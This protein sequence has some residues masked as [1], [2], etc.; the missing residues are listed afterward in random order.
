MTGIESGGLGP[1]A[2]LFSALSADPVKLRVLL[3]REIRLH[4]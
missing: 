2:F 4:F 1:A 3:L